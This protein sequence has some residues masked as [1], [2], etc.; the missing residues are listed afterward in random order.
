MQKALALM[1]LLA[2]AC[3]RSAEEQQVATP[4][5]ESEPVRERLVRNEAPPNPPA[6]GRAGGLSD[7]R[8]PIAEGRIDPKGPQGAAQVLQSYFA[9]IE[10]GK[11]ADAYRL[12]SDGGN[13]TGES[14]VQFVKSFEA[15]REFHANI[16]A[17]RGSE[18]AAGS[19]YVDVPVQLYG[20]TKHGE[21]FNA[22]G[23]MTLR[24][25]NDVPGS[26]AEQRAWHI[27]KSDFPKR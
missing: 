18:G 10:K 14:E 13:A 8:T 11:F 23:T 9:L 25:A 24:R 16:G 2:G 5:N 22:R 15:Y 20:R 19:I 17:P 1:L 12:W 26:T 3:S 27:Y 21:E 7:D 4:A 6:P